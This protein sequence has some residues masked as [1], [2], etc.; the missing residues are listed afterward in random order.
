MRL[1]TITEVDASLD[2]PIDKSFDDGPVMDQSNDGDMNIDDIDDVDIQDIE[3]LESDTN[4][5]QAAAEQAQEQQ[6]RVAEPL[7]N[8]L[9]QNF[10][11]ISKT[12]DFGR[13]TTQQTNQNMTHMDKQ[14]SHVKSLLRTLG[15]I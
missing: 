9:E 6:R 4:H 2:Q 13:G 5:I 10:D 8:K 11:Q 15:K 14:M 7:I 12:L 3:Q 1:H